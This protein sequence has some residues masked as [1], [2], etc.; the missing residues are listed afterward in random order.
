L[1]GLLVCWFGWSGWFA[2]TVARKDAVAQASKGNAAGQRDI[3]VPKPTVPFLTVSQ[4][5]CGGMH[6]VALTTSGHV[7]QWGE[8]WGDFSMEVNRSPR[9]LQ[10]SNVLVIASGAF[11]NLALDNS[12]RVL[13]W[14]T[15]DFGQLGTGDTAYTPQPRQVA[16]LDAVCVADIAAEGWHSLALSA[17][18]EVYTWGRGEYGRLGLNDPKGA[19]QVRPK[20]VPGLQGHRVIQVG[21]ASQLQRSFDMLKSV[22]A[23]SQMNR[24]MCAHAAARAVH[25]AAGMPH[26]SLAGIAQSVFA[27]QA[28]AGGSH[29]MALTD[30]GHMFI[31]GRCSNGRMGFSPTA[32]VNM[33]HEIQLPGGAERWHPICIAAGGRHSMCM[34]LPRHTVA[35]H[36]RRRTGQSDSG[37]FAGLQRVS[38]SI[39]QAEPASMPAPPGASSIA[40]RFQWQTRS[41]V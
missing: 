17:E 20:L 41:L 28:V 18:G 25:V 26:G 37:V 31:W 35:D 2:L 36:E 8:P 27:V 1:V 23:S 39:V 5:S 16:G 22:Q 14:G 34:A 10:V 3:C 38:N 33:P 24:L 32:T 6:S 12:N 13:A 29:T 30:K 19:A 9:Q 11:H 15:N 4:V 21:P 7:W 40:A